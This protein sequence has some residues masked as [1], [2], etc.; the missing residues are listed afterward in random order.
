[1][2]RELAI[3][4]PYAFF[5]QATRG[6]L[7]P[8]SVHPYRG[9]FQR[10]RDRIIHCSAFRRLSEKMQVFF[11][12]W[13]NYHRTRLTH[14]LEVTSVART[15]ARAL[16]LNEDLVEALALLHDVGHPPFGHTGEETLD[17]L[18]RDKGGFNHNRQALRIVEKLEQ[19]YP[20]YYGLN[21]SWETL[22]GQ[23]FRAIQSESRRDEPQES[24]PQRNEPFH[25][26]VPLKTEEVPNLNPTVEQTA[27]VPPFQQ[28]Q[29]GHL[30]ESIRSPF[31]EIQ[32][33][34]VADGIAYT[35]H[36]AD[37]A[38]ELGFLTVEELWGST[39]WRRAVEQVRKHWSNLTEQEFR[40]AAIHGLINEIVSDI[41]Q[42]TQS[43]LNEHQVQS[44]EDVLQ[45]PILIGPSEE[46]A[47]QQK[48]L[49]QLL[50][51]R[52]YR[53]PKVLKQ[54]EQ[55][56]DWFHTFFEKML[57]NPDSLVGPYRAVLEEEGE[58]RAIA[59]WIADQTDRVFQ[60]T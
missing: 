1:M 12:N 3:Q 22:L 44:V 29:Y 20:A 60:Q 58:H 21:L 28:V 42:S 14:T 32:V 6:R 59:D 23:E 13:G 52:V 45:L 47:Q 24:Q 50:F 41:F 15:L 38:L 18:L 2:S 25:T 17:D 30:P 54:R 46:V 7:H 19:R 36:D 48:E 11:A 27:W 8:E 40:R 39:L 31:L 33:V 37:D 49:S 35:S 55:V 56:R 34:D 53:H 51:D 9:P 5:S 26:V 10:D 4:A 57:R 43:R 16:Q